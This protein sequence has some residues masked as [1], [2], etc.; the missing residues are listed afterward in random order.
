[1]KSKLKLSALALFCALAVV[2]CGGGGGDS[3]A[4]DTASGGG[5]DYSNYVV[6][7]IAGNPNTP[8]AT[9]GPGASATFNG[10]RGI[11]LGPDGN[12]YVAENSNAK[13]RRVAPDGTVSTVAGGGYCDVA[14]GTSS[15][16][17]PCASATFR[18]PSGVAV[19]AG[20]VIYVADAWA[21]AIRKISS[22]GT[23]A[24]T[25]STLAGGSGK[26][27][28]DDGVGSQATFSGY[29]HWL[30]VDS[31]GNVYV[32]DS[33]LIRKVTPAGVVTTIAGTPSQLGHVD[34]PA[35]SAQFNYPQ[36][37]VLDAQ[38]NL[39]VID[40]GAYIRKI[41]PGG[42]VSTLAGSGAD[43]MG[44]SA[45]F[46]GAEGLGID[47]ASN[48]YV[49]DSGNNAI[50]KVT[51]NGMVTTIT[52]GKNNGSVDGPVSQASLVNPQGVAVAADGTI[53]FS[54]MSQIGGNY[55]STIRRIAP[56]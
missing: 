30:T 47:A 52:G 26:R 29:M 20:G 44:A 23:S 13:I 54:D 11:A 9:D 24:C 27:G 5:V 37:I 33:S 49:A 15:C 39:Y 8:G 3:P 38:G 12:L 48:L 2:A 53:Y 50:H 41:T 10:V 40:G 45:V 46:D 51:P 32:A 34:G 14:N 1:M 31:S 21:E 18:F 17:G 22:P 55:P 43:S 6:T 28:S 19:D 36:G 4:V 7:T 35:S 25:V 56:Q 42:T 16:D